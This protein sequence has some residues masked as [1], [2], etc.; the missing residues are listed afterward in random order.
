MS[1]TRAQQQPS[2]PG[3]C[4]APR[5]PALL[6][7]VG[8]RDRLNCGRHRAICGFCAVLIRHAG[9]DASAA[10]GPAPLRPDASR[11]EAAPKS[12]RGPTLRRPVPSHVRQSSRASQTVPAQATGAPSL[13]VPLHPKRS[14]DAGVP[15]PLTLVDKRRTLPPKAEASGGR[16]SIAGSAG[17]MWA[18]Q[19]IS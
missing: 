19:A 18:V 8:E 10:P 13:P 14:I 15:S 3:G 17:R 5:E 9:L 11:S 2:M 12:L 6:A 1:P 4:R 16:R 7:D